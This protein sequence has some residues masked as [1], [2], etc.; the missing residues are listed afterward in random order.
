VTKIFKF[1][2]IKRST[3]SRAR[4][5]RVCTPHGSF[6]TPIFV[7]VATQGV[8]KAL[9]DRDMRELCAEVL[10]ANTYHLHLR[11]GE[12]L[13]KEFG[14]LHKFMNWGGPLITDSGGFQAFSLGYAIEHQVGK[15]ASIFPDDEPIPEASKKSGKTKLAKVDEDGVT[16]KSHIDGK[17]MRLTPESSMEIQEKLGAD[18]IFAFDECTSPL[19]DY[20]YTKKSMERTHR[21]AVRSLAA[22]TK[23]DQALFG[24][25][26]GGA[27]EDLR[28][29]SAKFIGSLGFHGIGVGG[30]L[31]KS[32]HDMH[33]VLD[34]TIPLLP[35]DKPRHLLGIGAIEDLFECIERG[36]DMFDCV[37]PTR[38]ARSGH[39]FIG[40]ESGGSRKTKFRINI[41]N[42]RFKT[43]KDPVD[44]SCT[45]YTCKTFSAAYLHHL[46]KA[47]ELVYY[48]LASLHNVHFIL[49][50]VERIR[51]SIQ[52]DRFEELKDEW[53][54]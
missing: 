13:I 52:E 22:H 6:S 48:N 34:W 23:K 10:L 12:E 18:I 20:E 50:L 33:K 31:G 7:P 8:V 9:T 40:P 19:S 3:R 54:K 44:K 51:E 35:E 46:F 17:K 29:E 43:D 38:I 32:K 25:V 39:L 30:S 37:L 1:E 49:R 36:I 14:G 28:I 42:N 5:G 4:L 15:I 11:P 53:L 2:I 21:W 45:C 41:E 27:H 47:K 26:Q 16:F 24:I